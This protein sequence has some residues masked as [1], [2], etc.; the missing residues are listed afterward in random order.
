MDY[1][2]RVTFL[3]TSPL[4]LSAV[5][6]GTM[7]WIRGAICS[8]AVS[9]DSECPGRNKHE[10]HNADVDEKKQERHQPVREVES[11]NPEPTRQC[12]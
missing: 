5:G 6:E 10:E 1:L 4:I 11:K 7:E 8:I 12:Y 2:V 3:R 9:F